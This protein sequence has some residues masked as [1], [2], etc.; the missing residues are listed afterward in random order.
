[1]AHPS[2]LGLG[3]EGLEGICG[4]T[5]RIYF[6]S[7][8][9]HEPELFEQPARRAGS[10]RRDEA[11]FHIRVGAPLGEPLCDAPEGGPLI[12]YGV[13]AALK[14]RAHLLGPPARQLG[15]ER[16]R[17]RRALRDRER[18]QVGAIVRPPAEKDLEGDDG[19]G[20]AWRTSDAHVACTRAR[21][22][23]ASKRARAPRMPLARALAECVR[24]HAPRTERVLVDEVRVRLTAKVLGRLRAQEREPAE[25][26]G[27]W[28]ARRSVRGGGAVA[29][30]ARWRRPRRA[31]CI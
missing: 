27:R 24:G 26:S 23:R 2:S 13:P 4:A 28:R 21:D 3:S 9:G 16:L 8:R 10:E 17:A 15:P 25:G 7:E 19:C 20:E 11:P 30:A 12:G 1:M 14:Q 29:S 18:R 5:L 31:P 22:A 6:S